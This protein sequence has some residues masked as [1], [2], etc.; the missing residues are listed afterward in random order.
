VSAEAAETF[1]DESPGEE[2][3]R[4]FLHRPDAPNGNGLAEKDSPPMNPNSGEHG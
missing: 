1:P 4:G 3:V 2:R